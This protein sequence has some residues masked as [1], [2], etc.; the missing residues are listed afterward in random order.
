MARSLAFR[1][2]EEGVYLDNQ[3]IYEKLCDGENPDGLAELPKEKILS[4]VAEVFQKWERISEDSFDG[5]EKGSFTAEI[6]PRGVIFE[7]SFDM[8]FDALNVIIDIMGEF[9]CP[10]YDPQISE[11]FDGRS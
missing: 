10:L 7:C 1:K 4:R 8:Q 3:E 6:L 11:R 2:Y 9:G 5:G